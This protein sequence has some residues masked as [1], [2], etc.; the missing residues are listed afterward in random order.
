MAI[1][2]SADSFKEHKQYLP[3]LK[4]ALLLV[5]P[6]AQKK[7]LYFKQYPFGAKKL[8][9]VLVDFDANCAAA[10]AKAGHK[11]TDEGTVSL[12]PQ[13][14]LNFEPNK[15]ALKR[16]RLKKY[17]A[18]MGAGI[19]P[20]Y[21]PAGEVDDEEPGEHAIPAGEATPAPTEPAP[22]PEAAAVATPA[23]SP[24]ATQPAGT[25]S[26]EVEELQAKLRQRIQDLRKAA[27]PAE[28]QAQKDAALEKAASLV[29]AGKFSEATK[30]LDALTSR[31]SASVSKP[32]IAAGQSPATK[33][34][35]PPKLSAYMNATRDW[36]AAKAAAANGVF[37][38]KKAILAQC[39]AELETE[40]KAKIDSLNSV[41]TI[42]DDGI[43]V[44]IQE[45]GNEPDE[46]RQAERNQALVKF[47]GN[48]LNAL[49]TH[50]LAEVADNNPFG[51]FAI[52]APL[53]SVLT[54][55]SADFGI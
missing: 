7:F 36:K 44:K 42:M 53:E 39:D 34:S 45:A 26:P 10:L 52:R 40:V 9:L 11:P 46:E 49:R 23:A 28:L 8:P 37:A 24:A 35:G 48:L 55:I 54:K 29:A 25:P 47:A 41:L 32:D 3:L 1:F 33:P 50:P 16:I 21:V 20:V 17:F 5:K 13:D 4:R 6:D 15:G 12:T 27:F 38:L 19:K 43:V 2:S 18:T 22:I 51:S 14:E 31:M 30:L